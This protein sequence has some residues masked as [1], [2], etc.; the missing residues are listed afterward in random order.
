MYFS[1]DVAPTIL[2]EPEKHPVTPHSPSFLSYKMWFA[3]HVNKEFIVLQVIMEKVHSPYTN[4]LCRVTETWIFL[5]PPSTQ[6]PT[7]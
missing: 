2:P 7:E 5:S 3:K 1:A 4:Y 6:S